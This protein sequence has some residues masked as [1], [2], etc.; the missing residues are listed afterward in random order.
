[1]G[2][3]V[4][5]S[6]RIDVL[7]CLHYLQ[8]EELYKEFFFSFSI[9]ISYFPGERLRLMDKNLL[10]IESEFLPSDVRDT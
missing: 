3:T 9:P 5:I 10:P 8:Y 1:M 2:P 6:P 7:W 4:Y